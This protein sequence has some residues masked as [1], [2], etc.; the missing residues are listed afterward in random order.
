LTF[1]ADGVISL[2]QPQFMTHFGT[3]HNIILSTR[4][5]SFNS[6][7]FP[8]STFTNDNFIEWVHS[9]IAGG[10]DPF[11]RKVYG[12]NN[13]ASFYYSDRNKK[14]ITMKGGEVMLSGFDINHN[15]FPSFPFLKTNSIDLSFG[16]QLGINVSKINPGVDLG[17]LIGIVKNYKLKSGNQF[18][19]HGSY[20]LLKQELA[21]FGSGVEIINKPF[22]HSGELLSTYH[23]SLKNNQ[24][25]AISALIFVQSSY[26]NSDEYKYL[27][28]TGEKKS[29]FWG[30]GVS[31]LYR[32]SAGITLIA[33]Y[34]KKNMSYAVY[35]REDIP[36][37]NA[38]DSQTGVSVKLNW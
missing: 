2:Y 32:Y 37:N 13:P 11:A 30:Y 5:I 27:V 16:G 23:F 12:L 19:L 7:K 21:S 31:H 24:F 34:T 6:R 10:E 18:L 14:S 36:L 1:S 26:L 3:K 22:M 15:Y 38:P 29:S 9:N 4:I 25:L 17:G 33:S 20:G 8:F 28:L 35:F